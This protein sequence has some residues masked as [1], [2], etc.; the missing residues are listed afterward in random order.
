MR[1]A[2]N[3]VQ[4]PEC[5]S[6]F[7]LDVPVLYRDDDDRFLVYLMPLDNR[8]NWAAAENRMREITERLFD[9][10]SITPTCRLVFNRGDLIEKIALHERGLD[11]R[12][13]E[14]VKYQLYRNPY[15]DEPID[16]VR[17]R[18]LFDFSSAEKENLSF[19]IFDRE[20]GEAIAGTHLPMEDYAEVQ[21]TFLGNFKLQG[22]FSRLFP[23]YYVNVDRLLDGDVEI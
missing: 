4:C 15:W 14:Y 10:P 2:L 5:E 18:L 22:E 23:G 1:G 12:V 3:R 16:P 8:A 20:S 7:I 19:L 17:H 13:V 9:D 11:D 6:T 21:K